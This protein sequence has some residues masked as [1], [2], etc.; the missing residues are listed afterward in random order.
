ME[1]VY[2]VKIA[3]GQGK[4]KGKIVRLGHLGHYN[5]TDMYTMMSAFEATLSDL[6]LIDSFGAGIE[7]LRRSFGE[8][9][10]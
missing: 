6:R 5:A 1:R 7:A 9:K 10:T 3:G 8:A 4:I 2:G